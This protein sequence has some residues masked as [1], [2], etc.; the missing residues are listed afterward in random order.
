[1][2]VKPLTRGLTALLLAL[3]LANCGFKLAKDIGLPPELARIQLLTTDFSDKQR[4]MLRARL[5]RAGAEVSMTPVAGAVQ[6]RV[7]LKVLPQRRLVT[8]AGNGKNIERVSRGLQYSLKGADGNELAPPVSLLHQKDI[9]LD[10]DNLLSSTV[11]RKNVVEE[12]EAALYNRLV[13]Q[14]KRL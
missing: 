13:Q 3:A 2:R 14:L 5:Q 4:R 11:E 12:I 9:V 7:R 6:L 1:M 8:G 10:D